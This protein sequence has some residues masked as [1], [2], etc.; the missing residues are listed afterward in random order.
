M[1]Q[2][3]GRTRFGGCTGRS[4]RSTRT[5]SGRACTMGFVL[6]LEHPLRRQGPVAGISDQQAVRSATLLDFLNCD[7]SFLVVG[8]CRLDSPSEAESEV[9]VSSQVLSLVLAAASGSLGVVFIPGMRIT[10]PLMDGTW[11]W[12]LLA[13]NAKVDTLDTTAKPS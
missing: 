13:C 10:K 2:T 11:L 1:G 12:R 9:N 4:S 7:T 8:Q 3:E 6:E 5:F